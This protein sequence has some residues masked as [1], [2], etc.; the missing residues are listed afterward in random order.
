MLSTE[1]YRTEGVGFINHEPWL[2]CDTTD[3][4]IY[5]NEQLQAILDSAV[6]RHCREESRLK[7]E[8]GSKAGE[9]M[10]MFS[11]M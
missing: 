6:S 10:R 11:S 8:S 5:K 2:S 1:Y 9:F 7:L 3:V 4:Q